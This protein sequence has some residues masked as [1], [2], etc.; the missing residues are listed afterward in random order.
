MKTCP[1]C[2]APWTDEA[3]FCV[4]CMQGLS[5]KKEAP[6]PVSRK[7]GRRRLAAVGA[8]SLLVILGALAALF[9]FLKSREVPVEP[10]PE[11][12]RVGVYAD[13]ALFRERGEDTGGAWRP[14]ALTFQSENRLWRRY[15]CPADLAACVPE[16]YFKRDGTEVLV[17]LEDLILDSS[18][19]WRFDEQSEMVDLMGSLGQFICPSCPVDLTFAFQTNPELEN[20][21]A[22]SAEPDY[23]LV[24]RLGA[25]EKDLAG[26]AL[27]CWYRTLSLKALAPGARVFYVSR[28]REVS[29]NEGRLDVYFYF[30]FGGEELP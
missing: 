10:D 22:F 29:E 3:A 18:R 30:A 11:D 17:A 19:A 13:A 2:G 1:H 14:E 7:R 9:A 24:R 12:P 4:Y 15:T 28:I 23:D 21:P 26:T 5:E 20:N 25:G 6:L 16:V 8:A 27:S